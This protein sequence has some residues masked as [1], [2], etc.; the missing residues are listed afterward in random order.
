[1]YSS[2]E[3]QAYGNINVHSEDI[4]QIAGGVVS[5]V[6]VKSKTNVF[7]KN[8]EIVIDKGS[9]YFSAFDEMHCTESIANT[10][11]IPGDDLY[12][13]FNR[14]GV[15]TLVTGQTVSLTPQSEIKRYRF[16]YLI[17]RVTPHLQEVLSGDELLID[18]L[19]HYRCSEVF[20]KYLFNLHSLSD[21]AALY[22]KKCE[23]SGMINTVAKQFIEEGRL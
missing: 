8:A 7:R 20:N 18:I 11:T 10:F 2:F 23:V 9:Q 15:K 17:G 1:L 16:G 19:A 12:F 4:K 3:L 6:S 14:S 22:L 5:K 21:S 13:L